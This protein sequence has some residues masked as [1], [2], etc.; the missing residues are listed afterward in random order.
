MGNSFGFDLD[1]TIIDYTIT[2][3][4]YCKRTDL[5]PCSEIKSL[6]SYLRTIDSSDHSWQVAQSW[7]Y[8]DGLEF[9]AL[10][11]GFIELC[12]YLIEKNYKLYIV[13]HKSQNSSSASGSKPLVIP[14][15]NW[16]MQNKIFDYFRAQNIFFE[17]SQMKKIERIKALKLEGF[18]DDLEE[19]FSH[20]EFPVQVKR[21]LFGYEFSNVS[22][23]ISVPKLIQVKEYL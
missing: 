13:S 23:V 11:E 15:I 16:L 2:V 8:T 14:A 18:V 4:E 7:I 5:I 12:R 22:N 9:A 21:F 17:E 1:N 19:I 10:N 20:K 6:K 3:A